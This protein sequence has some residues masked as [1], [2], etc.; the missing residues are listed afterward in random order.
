[1]QRTSLQLDNQKNN[2]CKNKHVRKFRE[3]TECKR[4]IFIVKKDSHN[5]WKKLRKIMSGY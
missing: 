1:M 3:K 2:Y 4:E 5:E